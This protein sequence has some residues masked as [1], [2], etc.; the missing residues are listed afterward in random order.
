MKKKIESIMN[1][2]GYKDFVIALI[3]YEKNVTKT[4]ANDIYEYWLDCDQYTS[5]FD[6]GQAMEDMGYLI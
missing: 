5:I 4:K 1:N 3:M 2:M 6:L